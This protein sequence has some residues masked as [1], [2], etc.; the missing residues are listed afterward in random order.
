MSKYGERLAR[1]INEHPGYILP[2]SRRNE[3]LGFLR[4]NPL[5]DLCISRPAKRL[6]WGIPLPF[7]EDYVTYVWFDALLNYYSATKYLSPNGDAIPR[8]GGATPCVNGDAIPASSWW[9]ANLHIVGKD[10]LT[11][12]AVFWSTMLMALK[13]PLPECIF[14]HGWWTVEGKKMSKSLGNVVDPF[15]MAETYGADAFRYFLFRE[16]T[17]GLDGDFSEAALVGRINSDLANDLGN[18]VSRSL[19]MLKKYFNGVVPVPE[20]T[21]PKET[22]MEM[23]TLAEGILPALEGHLRGLQ[24]QRALDT[25]WELVTYLNKYIDTN[26]PWALAKDKSLEGRLG[27]VIYSLL[28]GIRFIS[29]YINPFMPRAS[30]AIY[31]ALTGGDISGGFDMRKETSWGKLQSGAR[32]T[33]L[34][35]LFPR[36]EHIIEAGKK[37]DKSEVLKTSEVLKIKETGP[38]D[39][40]KVDNAGLVSIED[41][42]KLEFK[43]GRVLL[44][45]RVKGSNK[46]IRLMVDTGEERQVVAGIGKH[47]EPEALVGKSVVVVANLKPAKLMGVESQGMVLA[48]S[49]G[50][51]LSLVTPDAA[52]PPG[53]RVK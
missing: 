48:A 46:L 53:S 43:V 14:A 36:I 26:K 29:L 18:L 49:S 34:A 27:T 52:M 6:S 25:V 12:H 8:D 37:P 10:I 44:A 32:T 35:A 50:D 45:E 31:A 5:G 24:F 42:A 51:A 4:T 21:V 38:M 11:T 39:T 9:P 23:K 7:D 47:Y 20:E 15:K 41:F 1:Y 16:V 40:E 19:A 3:V 13:M 28:E 22:E 2:E 30:A 17:F 33:A